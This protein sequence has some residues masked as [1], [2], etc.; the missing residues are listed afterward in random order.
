RRGETIE[1]PTRNV[2][3]HEFQVLAYERPDATVR[4]R[5]T[6]GTYVRSLCHDVG[7]QLGC[8]AVLAGLRRTWVGQ[9]TVENARLATDFKVR[10]DVEDRLL[11]I[12]QALDLPMVV[13]RSG[14]R[15]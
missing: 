8:G 13:I 6:R 5:C 4:V 11:P 10:S 12:D 9:H 14:S 1:R 7:Q 3:V 2:T 15:P